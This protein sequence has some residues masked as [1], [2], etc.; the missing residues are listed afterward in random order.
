M[1]EKRRKNNRRK[2]KEKVEKIKTTIVC[3]KLVSNGHR[4][5][6]PLNHGDEGKKLVVQVHFILALFFSR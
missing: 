3:L 5:A 4:K 6:L 1:W 2:K